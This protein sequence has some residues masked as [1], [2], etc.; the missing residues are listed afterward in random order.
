MA[1]FE[2]PEELRARLIAR[3]GRL[4]A[5]DVIEGAST[6]LRVVDMQNFFMQ[7][8]ELMCAPAARDIVPNVNRLAG[9]VRAA[10]RSLVAHSFGHAPLASGSTSA[11]GCCALWWTVSSPI[12]FG[13]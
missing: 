5:S 13:W 7:D 4:H 12:L 10:S 3:R 11:D 8:G 6:A 2:V 9:A 1:K